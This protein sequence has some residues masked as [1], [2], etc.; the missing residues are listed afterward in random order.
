MSTIITEDTLNQIVRIL[1]CF[2]KTE[3][4]SNLFLVAQMNPETYKWTYVF[5][6]KEDVTPDALLTRLLNVPKVSTKKKSLETKG[7]AHHEGKTT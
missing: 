5:E 7:A 6:L 1:S 4:E 3:K 2:L